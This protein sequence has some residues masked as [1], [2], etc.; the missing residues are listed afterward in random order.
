M[1]FYTNNSST[2]AWSNETSTTSVFDPWMACYGLNGVPMY[3]VPLNPGGGAAT[4]AMH[5]IALSPRTETGNAYD[6]TFGRTL[7]APFAMS[8]SVLVLKES[9]NS[10]SSQLVTSP[11]QYRVLGGGGASS[12]T[13][14]LFEPLFPSN[15][16][17]VATSIA[18]NGSFSQ[19]ICEGMY[20]ECLL[21]FR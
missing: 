1:R 11:D 12:G 7:V 10:N 9:N 15:A 14:L 3:M 4:S 8:A 17:G 5:T 20:P 16:S 6:T 13:P 2:A 19:P 21:A 18:L